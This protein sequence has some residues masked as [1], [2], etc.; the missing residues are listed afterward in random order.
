[1]IGI[2]GAPILIVGYITVMFGIFGRLDPLPA[3]SAVP[4][5]LFE[6]S[7]GIWLIFKGVN[8]SRYESIK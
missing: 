8:V 3:L 2:V 5:A 7:L 4:V 6:L 1:V